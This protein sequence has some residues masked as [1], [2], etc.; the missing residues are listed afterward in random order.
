MLPEFA[1]AHETVTFMYS[2]KICIC[3][4]EYCCLGKTGV[5]E[6]EHSMEAEMAYDRIQRSQQIAKFHSIFTEDIGINTA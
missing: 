3:L 2:L 6:Y 1:T 5:M 4:D